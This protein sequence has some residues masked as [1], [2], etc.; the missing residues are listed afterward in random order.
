MGWSGIVGSSLGHQKPLCFHSLAP[1]RLPLLKY[2]SE[3]R[4]P[5]VLLIPPGTLLRRFALECFWNIK[6]KLFEKKDEERPILKEEKNIE[7]A[8]LTT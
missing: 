1:N 3:T 2:Q 8:T 7:Y 5:A 4:D 6:F